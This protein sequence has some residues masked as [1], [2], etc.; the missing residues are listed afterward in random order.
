MPKH[1]ETVVLVDEDDQEFSTKYLV[2]KFGLSA[3]WRGFSISHKLLEGD[4]L[5]FQLIKNWK[6]KVYN[7]ND[8]VNAITFFI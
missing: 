1:D 6:F 7:Y 8:Q 4:A 3:G 5:V 2:H